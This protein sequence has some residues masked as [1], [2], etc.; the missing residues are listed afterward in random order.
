MPQLIPLLF[1]IA[2]LIII[3]IINY[4]LALKRYR[5][6]FIIPTILGI[7]GIAL[8]VFAAAVDLGWASLGYAILGMI[9]IIGGLISA[10]ASLI[11]VLYLRKQDP[12]QNKLKPND[13]LKRLSELNRLFREGALSLD[14]YEQEKAKLLSK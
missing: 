6:A 13:D 2:F 7:I 11:T 3:G 10:S 4:K 14:E 5:Y 8:I 1:I 9:A 12:V